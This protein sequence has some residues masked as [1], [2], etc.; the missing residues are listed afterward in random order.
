[1]SDLENDKDYV[2]IKDLKENLSLTLSEDGGNIVLK[3]K[4]ETLLTISIP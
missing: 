1:M 4:E 2:S 3:Y